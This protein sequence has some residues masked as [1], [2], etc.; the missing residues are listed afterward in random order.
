MPRLPIF[1]AIPAAFLLGAALQL[2][3][4]AARVAASAA[5]KADLFSGTA[6]RVYRL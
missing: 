4:P 6:S 2:A 1:A 3:S 5:Q